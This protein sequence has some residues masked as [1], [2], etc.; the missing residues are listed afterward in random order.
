MQR[1]LQQRVD[2]AKYLISDVPLAHYAD[3]ALVLTAVLSACAAIRWP[4][5]CG[6]DRRRFIELLVSCSPE[7][8][9]T[10]WVSVP[11]LINV[12]LVQEA[13]TPYGQPGQSTRIFRDED[14]D[15]SLQKAKDKY[16]VSER[17]LRKRCYSSLIY[18]WL[19]C[20]YAHE[21][22]P[23]ENITHVPA[24]R[25]TARISYIGRSTGGEQERVQR[26][27][28]IHL[29]YLIDLADYHVR[30]MPNA[31]SPKPTEWWTDKP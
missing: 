10:S 19:R 21:Y 6:I 30:N 1:F 16:A 12:G 5:N 13:D 22:V 4:G 23:N 3:V 20:G 15:L 31:P 29:E 7:H 26:M 17:K 14:I 8:F 18:D 24:S 27:V 9:H 11:A 2:L 28:S 25:Y